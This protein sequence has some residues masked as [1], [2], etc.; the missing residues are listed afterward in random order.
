MSAVIGLASPET[1]ARIKAL[2][3][4]PL[5][6]DEWKRRLAIPLSPEEIEHTQ[7]LVRWFCRRYPT[8]G[9]RFAYVRRAYKRWMGQAK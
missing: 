3:E 6:L 5:P 4:Q 7:A 9:E 1:R 8:V 2:A